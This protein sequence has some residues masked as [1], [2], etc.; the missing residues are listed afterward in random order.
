VSLIIF[1]AISG[2]GDDKGETVAA[3]VRERDSVASVSDFDMA[4]PA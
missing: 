4:G 3:F 1:G 2:E